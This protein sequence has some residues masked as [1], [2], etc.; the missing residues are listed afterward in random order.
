[1]MHNYLLQ[2]YYTKEEVNGVSNPEKVFS[3]SAPICALWI[4]Q[5][6]FI[7]K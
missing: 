6:R 2:S 4:Y 3:K 5:N 1:M 7:T